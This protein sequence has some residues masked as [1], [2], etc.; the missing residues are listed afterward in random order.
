MLPE[1]DAVERAQ[2]AKLVSHIA[3][4]S[5]KRA[6]FLGFEQFMHEALYSAGLGYYSAGAKKLGRDGDFVTAPEISPLFGRALSAQ[7]M[8]VTAHTTPEILELGAGSGKLALQVLNAYREAQAPLT[9]YAILEV[10]ADLASRQRSLLE[11]HAPDLVSSVVWL[12][13]LPDQIS[14][15]VIANEVLDA[16]PCRL[17]HR[18]PAG[19]NE[20]GVG[21]DASGAL[22]WQERRADAAFLASLKRLVSCEA[23]LAIGYRAEFNPQAAALVATLATRLLAGA[24]FIIDYGFPAREFYH[25]ARHAGT[26][27]A[28]YRH[29]AHTD[30]LRSPGLQDLTG[31]VDFTALAHAADDANATL[32]GY[33]SQASFLLNCGILELIDE[34]LPTNAGARLKGG[35]QT[36]LSEAEMGELFKV[37]AF[38]RGI[39]DAL[40]G[41][42]RGDRLASL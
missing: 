26:L 34:T 33:T 32:M 35:V 21:I 6:G 24:A 20:V 19:W 29:R 7:L 37:L 25:P 10:S 3:R 17:A 30:L 14:G 40:I 9:R 31:H 41:F 16:V 4:L 18:D 38:G 1:P 5:A 8:Q 27:M 39:E 13:T 23:E 28:H 22:Q 42:S 15:A 11:E 2:S 36:L 12:D